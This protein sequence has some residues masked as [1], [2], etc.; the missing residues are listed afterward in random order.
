VPSF[1][2]SVFSSTAAAAAADAVAE[3]AG[4]EVEAPG[5]AVDVDDE[6]AAAVDG[7]ALGVDDPPQAAASKTRPAAPTAAA[8]RRPISIFIT[9]SFS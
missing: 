2:L 6:D 8:T 9:L 7:D 4:A 5:A 3:A 1:V